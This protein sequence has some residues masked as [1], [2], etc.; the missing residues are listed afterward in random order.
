MAEIKKAKA[1]NNFCLVFGIN[2]AS[3]A[4]WN[5]FEN[6]DLYF[7]LEFNSPGK[8]LFPT[9]EGR[10]GSTGARHVLLRRHES[11]VHYSE[12]A[13]VLEQ[14]GRDKYKMFSRTTSL[15][16]FQASTAFLLSFTDSAH[17]S[18]C[19]AETKEKGRSVYSFHV[20]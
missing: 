6:V 8:K 20:K 13:L 17:F 4:Y 16:A 12:E 11:A 10:R 1:A 5:L 18:F 2:W 19:A 14:R 7:G 15:A 3:S 9:M